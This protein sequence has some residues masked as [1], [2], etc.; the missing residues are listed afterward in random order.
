LP[1]TAGAA[2]AYF[3]PDDPADLARQLQRLLG[4]PARRSELAAAGLARAAQF[5][6]EHT[7]R[8]TA[9]VYRELL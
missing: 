9:D 4:D 1:E 7:A 5:S 3:E 2:A 8:A 6:W